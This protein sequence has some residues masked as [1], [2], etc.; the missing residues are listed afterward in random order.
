MRIAVSGLLPVL[1][2]AALVFGGGA[3]GVR[4]ALVGGVKFGAQIC[5]GA[6]C[7]Q[8]HSEPRQQ[9]AECGAE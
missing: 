5:A 8:P 1:F 7:A 4:D 3:F 9:P 2:G 6:A